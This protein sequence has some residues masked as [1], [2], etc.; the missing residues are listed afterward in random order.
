MS[1][2]DRVSLDRAVRFGKPFVR[3]IRITVGRSSGYLASDVS[4]CGGAFPPR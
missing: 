2:L 3:G 1:R 4:K